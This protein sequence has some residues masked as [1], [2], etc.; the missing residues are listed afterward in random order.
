MLGV[1]RVVCVRSKG[2][3]QT[4]AKTFWQDADAEALE[5]GR[6]RVLQLEQ[7][8]KVV[9]EYAHSSAAELAEARTQLQPLWVC[10]IYYLFGP[11]GLSP[12]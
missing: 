5:E 4:F 2:L 8:L 9:K 7:E 1:L 12:A 3:Q 11:A 6:H 10:P